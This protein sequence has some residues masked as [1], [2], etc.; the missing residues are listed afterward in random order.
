M[1]GQRVLLISGALV[2]LVFIF[3]TPM[4]L[5]PMVMDDV[6]DRSKIKALATY[7]EAVNIV[8]RTYAKHRVKNL[9]GRLAPL[10]VNSKGW[11]ELINP[12]GRKAPGGGL[13]ILPVA[14]GNTGA[15]GLEG[16]RQ[17]VVITLPGYRDM[18]SYSTVVSLEP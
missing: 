11:I 16:D 6:P 14:D 13:A 17:Q 10:P 7:Q 4:V 1:M 2:L 3:G 5:V 8:E 18:E 9:P 15:I 12:M